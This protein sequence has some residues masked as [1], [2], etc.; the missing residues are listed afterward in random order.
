MENKY[1]YIKMV[2][3]VLQNICYCLKKVQV[4]ASLFQYLLGFQHLAG[5]NSARV[6]LLHL[7]FEPNDIYFRSGGKCLYV[8]W[9]GEASR[10]YKYQMFFMIF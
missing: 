6:P 10:R 4:K 7:V 3:V 1:K 2:L 8:G 5:K 9:K